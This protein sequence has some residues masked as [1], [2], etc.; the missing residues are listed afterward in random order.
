MSV[1][2]STGAPL[3]LLGR[4]VG[5]RADQRAFRAERDAGRL[6]VERPERRR[7]P[8]SAAVAQLGEAEVEQLDAAVAVSITLPGFRSRWMMP[9]AVRARRA[10]RR[11]AAA[12]A[13]PRRAAA[14]RASSRA[15]S[16]S[17][18]RYSMTRNRCR[19]LA[20]VVERADVRMRERRDGARFALEALRRSR[21]GR[22]R[23][24]QDLD[25]DGASEA[26][27]ARR[28]RPR[29]CRPC[30]SARRSYG[31]R[32]APVLTVTG[33]TPNYAPP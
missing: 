6:I 9:G 23:R 22:E 5:D 14:G 25:R 32:R 10:R 26:R 30:R 16:V 2:A 11:S 7:S 31:P 13:A 8:G 20:D 17:P 4:H 1:R 29:P 21:I 18:S 24:R 12:S 15:A 3:E 19:L 28:D 33:K 27:V